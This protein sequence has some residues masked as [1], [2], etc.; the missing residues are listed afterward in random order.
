MHESTEFKN[1]KILKILII[2]L[3]C[4]IYYGNTIPNQYAYDDAH[5]INN[6]KFTQKGISGIPD[7]FK[8]NTFVGSGTDEKIVAGGRY[9]PLSVATFAIEYQFFGENPHISHYFNILFFALTAILLYFFLLKI[10]HFNNGNT[11]YF[12]F[13]FITTLLFVAHPVH[14]EII[15]NI[16]GRD[17][18]MAL[19]GSLAA[20]IYILK[21]LDSNKINHLV[22][23]FL[24]FLLALFSK[25]NAITFLAIIPLSIYY[26]KKEKLSRYFYSLIPLA[27]ASILFINIRKIALG[28][29]A[30]PPAELM[31]N[32]FIIATINQKYAT[33]FYTLGI[34]I[35]LLF[36]PH[37]LTID[38][39]PF[40]IPLVK[41]NNPIALISLIGYIILFF[42]A[43]FNLN[44]KSVISYGILFYLITLSI[45]SNLFFPIG[46]FMSERFIFMPSIGFLIIIGWFISTKLPTIIKSES[47]KISILMLIMA[48]CF[49]KTYSRNKAW[50]DNFTL[51]STDV[52]TS[53]NSVK[54][55]S[56][57]S[58]LMLEKAD[59]AEDSLVAKKYQTESLQFAKKTYL[60]YP[61]FFNGV[62]QLGNS[63]AANN[64]LDS[65]FFCYEKAI[66]M[67]PDK[68]DQIYNRLISFLMD[69]TKDVDFKIKYYLEFV[70]QSPDNFYFNYNLGV[71][72]GRFKN[73]KQE[74]VRY[75]EKAFAIDPNNFEINKEL[76]I[77]YKVSGN[78]LKS[79]LCLEKAEQMNPRDSAILQNLLAIYNLLGNKQKE[80]EVRKIIESLEKEKISST[81]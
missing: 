5:V 74:S 75:L 20:T 10:F 25:E 21:Y 71:L 2:A 77:A 46:T 43:L 79:S 49:I 63:Y 34:Y 29:I 1:S 72:Y 27:L 28:E 32:P 12:D 47:F 40:Y 70:R 7:I 33:I 78:Y 76:G 22:S 59:Q 26:Y 44:R 17:E 37:P 61:D 62:I 53:S 4:F 39:Y 80:E 45:V 24:F 56:A 67:Q 6:N 52:I 50:K 42:Y 36:F 58:V 65:A 30:P 64:I 69:K 3:A 55:N 66:G 41:W 81:R 38:Y 11:R 9:R 14:S 35:K 51:F 31:N 48:L 57:M 16:K 73:N 13:P 60:L 19:A 23:A 8:Y 54:T 18:I 15:A 68:T